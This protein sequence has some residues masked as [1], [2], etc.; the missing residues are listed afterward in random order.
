M[1]GFLQ[2]QL[3]RE[4]RLAVVDSLT[5]DSPKTK[6]L[7]AKFKAMGLDSVLVITDQLDD[8]LLLA[9]RNLV[10]VLIVE[11]RHADPL[12]LVH[13]KKVLVTKAA[14]EQLKEMLA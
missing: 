3:A 1:D 2:R 6:A 7:A 9:S 4:G 14:V 13:Y 8:N 10:N 12:A 5:V 11:P